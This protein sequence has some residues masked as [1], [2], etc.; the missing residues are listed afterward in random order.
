MPVV[1]SMH[2]T[3][4]MARAT[5]ELAIDGVLGLRQV[6]IGGPL[7]GTGYAVARGRAIG[8]FHAR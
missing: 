3:A 8:S 2:L 4:R 1:R 5:S 6:S 7:T